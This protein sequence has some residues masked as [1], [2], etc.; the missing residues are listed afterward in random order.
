[1]NTSTSKERKSSNTLLKAGLLHAA[2]L[3]AGIGCVYSVK[4][5]EQRALKKWAENNHTVS[6]ESRIIE[7]A[8]IPQHLL[9]D[10]TREKAVAL[11]E[12]GEFVLLETKQDQENKAYLGQIVDKNKKIIATTLHIEPINFRNSPEEKSVTDRIVIKD[13][14]LFIE[15]VTPTFSR[16]TVSSIALKTDSNLKL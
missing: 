9:P 8:R 15:N 14:G 10:S 16:K 7:S 5:E 11:L 12:A 3:L 1:M 6:R 13:M 4:T 2:F